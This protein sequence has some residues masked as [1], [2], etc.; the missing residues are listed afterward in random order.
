MQWQARCTSVGSRRLA[1]AAGGWRRRRHVQRRRGLQAYASARHRCAPHIA[2][3]AGHLEPAE[4]EADLVRA[5]KG[6]LGR[7]GLAGRCVCDCGI[8]KWPPPSRP[9]LAHLLS[10]W[11]RRAQRQQP[12]VTRSDLRCRVAQMPGSLQS[13][14]RQGKIN[15]LKQTCA[16][17]D[18]HQI[19]PASIAAAPAAG[20][21][22]CRPA[23]PPPPAGPAR[24]G[25]PG[26]VRPGRR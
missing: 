19:T 17:T 6:Y 16:C 5:D 25:R 2:S 24:R 12:A 26:R 22:R 23:P 14:W 10:H 8:E 15:T 21:P 1:A 13:G 7:W 20:P 9:T 4:E 3:R 18:K 11:R